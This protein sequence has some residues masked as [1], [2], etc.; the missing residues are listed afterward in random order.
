M[1][2]EIPGQTISGSLAGDAFNKERQ[3]LR[4]HQPLHAP[5]VLTSHTVH[6]ISREAEIPM[7]A[8]A[9]DAEPASNVGVAMYKLKSIQGD[10]LTCRTW[11]GTNEGATDVY[12]AKPSKLRTSLAGE[13]IDGVN[14]TYAYDANFVI[15]AAS[16]AGYFSEIHYVTPR[17]NINNLIY[18]ITV[19]TAVLRAGV[20]VGKLDLNVDARAWAR[21]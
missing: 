15:R 19:T 13:V 4:S 2:G 3:V 11:D 8:Y 20:E 21:L 5:G 1:P 18:A 7:P 14:V 10:Y 16:A 9:Q 6:G 17:Y 12:I